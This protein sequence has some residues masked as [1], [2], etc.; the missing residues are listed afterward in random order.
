MSSE[1]KNYPP[2]EYKLKK[3]RDQGVMPRSRE[4]MLFA[5]ISGL[6]CGLVL[7][8]STA[9]AAMFSELSASWRGD[10]LPAKEAFFA[11]A[12]IFFAFSWYILIPIG[13]VVLLIG[14]Y[15][16]GF[17]FAGNLV[18]FDLGRVFRFGETLRLRGAGA[19]WALLRAA[20]WTAVTVLILRRIL[21]WT[22]APE[23]I[24]PGVPLSV[25]SWLG[26]DSGKTTENFLQSASAVIQ[27]GESRLFG[28]GLT[29]LGFSFF[30]GVIS[31]FA[32]VMAFR[33]EHG[34]SRAEIEAENRELESPP[35]IKR[36]IGDLRAE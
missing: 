30:L 12:K 15:Q 29:V 28:V 32:A 5:A 25:F 2:S 36:R 24:R 33:N 17:L 16:T 27:E 22:A 8:R 11:A 10:S 6:F 21:E 1:L 35:D 31:R 7:L 34:M 18:R 9:T 19:L 14:T 4:L 23:P 26:K 20:A 13:A 3:L